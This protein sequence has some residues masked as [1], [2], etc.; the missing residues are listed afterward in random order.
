MPVSVKPRGTPLAAGSKGSCSKGKAR[1]KAAATFLVRPSASKGHSAKCAVDRAPT[2]VESP[3]DGPGIDTRLTLIDKHFDRFACQLWLL[4]EDGYDAT[5]IAHRYLGRLES[6]YKLL[7]TGRERSSRA[8]F[9]L[10]EPSAA[11]K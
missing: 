1:A 2:P 6:V 4:C 11:G 7:R 10:C 5:G 3:V 9:G 8:L